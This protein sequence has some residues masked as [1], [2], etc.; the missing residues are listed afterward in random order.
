MISVKG[1]WKVFGVKQILRDVSFEVKDGEVVG[2][3]GPSGSGKST[4]LNILAGLLEPD[5]GE[6]VIDD[7]VVTRNYAGVNRVSIPPALRG[8]GYV[9]QDS[10]LFPNLTVKENVGFG[11]DSQGFSQQVIEAK[12]NEL[13][14]MVHVKEV[15]GSYPNQLSGGQQKRVALARTLAVNPKLLLMDE[16]LTSLDPDLKEQLMSDLIKIFDELCTTV[17]YVTHDLDEAGLMV[18]RIIRLEESRII[19]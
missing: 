2:L 8:L 4:T 12:V 5:S 11:P 7:V 19:G 17:I 13:L 1:I 14:S 15:S 10:A 18:D 9:M 6:V 16:P 3:V